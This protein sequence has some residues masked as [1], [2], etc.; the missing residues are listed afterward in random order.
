MGPVW[1]WSIRNA[2]ATLV[3]AGLLFGGSGDLGWSAAWTFV[4]SYV[5]YVAVTAAVALVRHPGLLAERA[6]LHLA[7]IAWDRWLAPVSGVAVPALVVVFAAVDHRFGWAPLPVH[8]WWIGVV[9]LA[10]GYGLLLAAMAANRFFSAGVRIQ[11]ERGHVTIR[12]GPYAVIRHPG[13]A[14]LIVLLLA[15]PVVLGSAIALL[16]AALAV[17]LTVLRAAWEDRLLGHALEGYTAYAAAVPYRLAPG[18]W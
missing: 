3:V 15:T 2:L 6:G 10:T 18:L 17:G 12:N 5:V 11:K 4:G 7:T 16:P 13:Y 14:G 1:R 9:G 8:S